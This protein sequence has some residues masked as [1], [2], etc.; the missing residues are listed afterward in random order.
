MWARGTPEPNDDSSK[1]GH[2]AISAIVT[3]EITSCD[4]VAELETVFLEYSG[5]FSYINAAAALVKYAKLRG[6]SM[7]SPFFSKLAAVWLTRLPEA[8]PRQCANVLWVCSKLGSS[9]HPVWIKTWKAFIG[10]VEKDLSTDSPPSVQPQ[11]FSNV[12][13]ACANLRK[14]P[15]PDEL[16]LLC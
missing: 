7:R 15:Q 8:E 3:K 4:S 2:D 6:S 12:L 13:Y 14:Q 9:E 5:R 10:L 16:L 1:F 11:E